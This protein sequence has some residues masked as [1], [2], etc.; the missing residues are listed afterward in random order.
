[1]EPLLTGGVR[2]STG[3]HIVESGREVSPARYLL[4]ELP[5]SA[6]I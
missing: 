4:V 5:R 1:M 3:K 2:M 6:S